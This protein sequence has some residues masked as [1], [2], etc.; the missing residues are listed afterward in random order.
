MQIFPKDTPD[1]KKPLWCGRISNIIGLP[2][3]EC[4]AR[5]F[6]SNNRPCYAPVWSKLIALDL[7]YGFKVWERAIG[8]SPPMPEE[9]G[10][11]YDRTKS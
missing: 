5:I 3:K 4:R 9:Y 11:R 6:D 1:D 2:Y 10:S 8:F 7:N